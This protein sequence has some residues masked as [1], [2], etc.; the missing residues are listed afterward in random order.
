MWG[1]ESPGRVFRVLAITNNLKQASFRLRLQS[2]VE[3]LGRRGLQVDVQERPRSFFARRRLLRRASGFDAV[4]LQRKMLDPGDMRLL[5]H[6]SRR[7]F[8]DV[9]DAV[10]FHS[11]PVGPIERCRTRRRFV[12]TAQNS[13]LVVA[14]NQYL[15]ELFRAEGAKCV[16][17][18]TCVEPGHYQVKKH[19]AGGSPTLVWIGSSSTLPYLRESFAALGAA[20]ARV[21]GLRLLVIADRA[22]EGCPIPTEHVIWSEESEAAALGRGDIGIAPTPSDPWTLGKCGFKIVQYMAAGLPVIAS[23]VGA[24]AEIVLGE[25]TGLLPGDFSDWPEAIAT[26]AGDVEL[27]NKMGAAGRRRVEDHFSIE[28]AADQWARWLSA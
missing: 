8:F 18:P 16:V 20:A 3:P 2:L 10:M 19:E 13:N 17:L 7:I 22:P 12:A 26:L 23:P 24:N 1:R 28:L 15:A 11:R 25:K 4:L 14:G 9:D 6:K 27:R 21:A 5:R